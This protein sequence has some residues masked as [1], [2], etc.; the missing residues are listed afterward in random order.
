MGNLPL[1]CCDSKETREYMRLNFISVE[2]LTA[3]M[4][5]VVKAVEQTIGADMPDSFG[6]VVTCY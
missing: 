3:I 6:L 5:A 2:T 4:E 1:S